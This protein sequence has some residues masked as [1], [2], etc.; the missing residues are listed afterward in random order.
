MTLSYNRDVRSASSANFGESP[1]LVSRVALRARVSRP[2][3]AGL[4]SLHDVRSYIV[5][6]TQIY[7]EEEQDRWLA[8]RAGESGRTKSELIREAVDAYASG[9]SAEVAQAERF[10]ASLEGT[11]GIA[12]YL[13]AGAEHVR[14]LRQAD[15]KRAVELERRWRG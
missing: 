2:S 10:R 11:F 5:K 15:E 9:P 8:A 13:P 3:E 4:I 1:T 14:K 7:I 12:R 6:R